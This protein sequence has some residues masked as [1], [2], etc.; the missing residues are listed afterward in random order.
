MCL[1]SVFSPSDFWVLVLLLELLV[2]F[3]P[4]FVT[5]AIIAVY[6]AVRVCLIHPFRRSICPEP[7]PLRISSPEKHKHM[8]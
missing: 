8:H 5:A 2:I 1:F 6:E 4:C 3:I 7:S